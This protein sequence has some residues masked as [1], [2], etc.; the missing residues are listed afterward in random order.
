MLLPIILLAGSGVWVVNEAIEI[1]SSGMSDIIGI[2][3]A[4]SNGLLCV[5]ICVFWGDRASDLLGRI[6]VVLAASGLAILT[7]RSA[8]LALQGLRS[9]MAP[10]ISPIFLVG[11]L[12]IAAGVILIGVWVIRSRAFP[13]W[14]GAAMIFCTLLSLALGLLHVSL[15]IQSGANIVLAVILAE[16]AVLAMGRRGS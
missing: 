14:I 16:T 10:T 12:G 11:A 2:T 13:A 7:W 1:F 8:S 3:G 15:L 4:L 9:D 5:G 6:G